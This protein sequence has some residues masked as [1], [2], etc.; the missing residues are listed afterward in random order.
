[1][2]LIAAKK[3]LVHWSGAELQ[4]CKEKVNENQ[5]PSV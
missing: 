1:M 4:A 5:K 2:G 3:L